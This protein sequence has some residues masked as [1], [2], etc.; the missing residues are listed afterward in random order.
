MNFLAFQIAIVKTLVILP[1]FITHISRCYEENA[2]I[3]LYIVK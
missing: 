1:K 3:V 2:L